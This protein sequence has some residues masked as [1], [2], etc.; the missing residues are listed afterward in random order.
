MHNQFTHLKSHIYMCMVYCIIVLT[1]HFAHC[2]FITIPITNIHRM[3][4]CLPPRNCKSPFALL[5]YFRVLFLFPNQ[6]SI[7]AYIPQSLFHSPRI[8]SSNTVPI[9]IIH[10]LTC[11]FVQYKHCSVAGE[12]VLAWNCI[13]LHVPICEANCPTK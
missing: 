6:K 7:A 12:G 3:H 1:L 4:S 9:C 8:S 2:R 11:K 5:H 13:S 10:C